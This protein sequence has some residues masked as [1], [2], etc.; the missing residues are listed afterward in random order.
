MIIM[1][2]RIIMIIIITTNHPRFLSKVING[3]E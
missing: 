2:T 3:G 1:I